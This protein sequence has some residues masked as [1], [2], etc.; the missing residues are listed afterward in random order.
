LKHPFSQV[1]RDLN[2]QKVPKLTLLPPKTK[3][4]SKKAIVITMKKEDKKNEKS[5]K[6]LDE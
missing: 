6:N 5:G 4:T 2:L 1:E 3:K